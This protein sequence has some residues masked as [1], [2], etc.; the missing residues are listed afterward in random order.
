MLKKNQTLTVVIESMGCNME[1]VAKLN[2]FVIF[3]PFTIIGEK[4]EIKILKVQKDFA[5]GKLLKVIQASKYR[6]Q[7]LCPY[8][9]KCGGCDCQHIDYKY[10]CKLKADMVKNTLEH[11][12][13]CSFNVNETVASINNYF[14][15]NKVAFP[16]SPT[17]RTIGMFAPNSHRIIE[18]ENCFIQEKWVKNLIEV[19]NDYI[20]QSNIEIYDEQTHLGLLKYVVARSNGKDVLVTM[21]VNGNDIKDKNL[22]INQLEKKFKDFGVNLNI[23]TQKNNV[24]LSE[25]FKHIYGISD[26]SFK[27][28]GIKYTVNNASFL[29]VNNYIKNEIYSAV[30]KE[31]S[32]SENVIDGY[33][34]AGLMTAMLST[35]AKHV[36]GVEVVKQAVDSANELIKNNNIKNVTNICGKCEVEIPKLISKLTNATIV[37]DPPRKGCDLKVIEAIS[38]A[39]PNKIIY[40]SCAPN[41]LARDIKNLMELSGGVYKVKNITPFDMFPQTK[42]IETMCVLERID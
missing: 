10:A 15:R 31:I 18:I 28:F 7:P 11:I 17:T 26:L 30:M 5:Y 39:K 9:S 33:S 35:R 4:V 1:G 21:V 37:L 32:N 3:V 29:Q 40:V 12:C 24:I 25:K 22:L 36:Y 13:K 8:F 38:V 6:V 2:G 27:E 34:G 20:K 14:Y 19:I 23:N 41:T 16:V 42:H